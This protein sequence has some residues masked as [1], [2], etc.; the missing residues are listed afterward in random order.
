MSRIEEITRLKDRIMSCDPL[1]SP[2]RAAEIRQFHIDLAQL[3]FKYGL[4]LEASDD[5]T[6]EIID[7]RREM[8]KGYT[9][10]AIIREDGKLEITTWVPE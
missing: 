4:K 7:A 5:H 8:P 2:E 9:F 1:V 3:Q 10:S 6:F